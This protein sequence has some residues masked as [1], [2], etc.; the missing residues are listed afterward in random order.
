MGEGTI[1]SLHIDPTT[2]LF[3]SFLSELEKER[4]RE[5]ESHFGSTIIFCLTPA[6]AVHCDLRWFS[7]FI[8]QQFKKN[9]NDIAK[10]N[11]S[12]LLNVLISLSIQSYFPYSAQIHQVLI[13]LNL[14]FSVIKQFNH[15]MSSSTFS[16]SITSVSLL[17]SSSS[18]SHSLP[19]SQT[20]LQSLGQVLT[21]L[22]A[23]GEVH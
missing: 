3:F 5:R 4:E 19:F 1:Y 10:F 9:E 18:L 8:K 2:I 12:A 21:E 17:P 6:K 15:K 11:I 20:L 16:S 22:V 13:L 7:F 23:Y 14:N